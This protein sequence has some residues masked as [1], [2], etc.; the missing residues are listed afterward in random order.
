M[1]Y[2]KKPIV[3]S[4]IGVLVVSAFLVLFLPRTSLCQNVT[5][6]DSNDNSFTFAVIGDTQRF[7]SGK[8]KG[9]LQRASQAIGKKRA[10]FA[11]AMGDLSSACYGDGKCENKL[12]KWRKIVLADVPQVYPVMG[13][14]DQTNHKAD[15]VWRRVFDLPENGPDDFKE[16]AYSFDYKNSHFVVLNSGTS[17]TINQE[18]QDW[19]EQD[20]SNNQKENTFIFFHEPAWPASNKINES[21]DAHPSE[22]DQLWRIFDRYNVTAVFSGHEH[23]Y[24]RRK[25]TAKQLT[26]LNNGIYQFIVGNTDSFRHG[27]PKSGRTD[28]YFTNKNYAVV[29]VDGKEITIKDYSVGGRVMDEFKFTQ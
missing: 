5:P 1:L 21:L 25:I 4:V 10:A 29:K 12:K 15:G 8:K 26:G 27:K 18:Q 20:L 17:H 6:N 28:F 13:N 2:L 14:H 11:V 7:N 23:M 22:R 19:L 24:S 16:I 9:G 3:L